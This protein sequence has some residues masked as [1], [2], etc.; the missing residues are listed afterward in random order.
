MTL[1]ALVKN[2]PSEIRAKFTHHHFEK[3]DHILHA[4]EKNEFLFFLVAG[5][6]EVYTL[7]QEGVMLSLNSYHA[8]S[9]FGEYEVF[10]P[11]ST[12]LSIIAKTDCK[13]IRIHKSDLFRWMK[14]DFD[15]SMK[16]LNHFAS[17]VINSHK[18]NMRLAHL[19][20]KERVLISIHSHYTM[21]NL[22]N[23][24]KEILIQEALAPI[25][26]VNR[27]LVSLKADGILDY[28]KKQFLI[29]DE[30]LLKEAV[31]QIADL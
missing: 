2:A 11:N 30:T 5:E 1:D 25:R 12:T 27:A 18:M 23:L 6:A 9:F 21:D 7:T 10:D 26:S 29:L 16:I 13:V 3:G 20:I 31:N 14:N 19:T 8:T 17:D 15:L 22:K 28:R 24:T 4:G